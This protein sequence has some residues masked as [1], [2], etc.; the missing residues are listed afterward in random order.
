MF[1]QEVND[2]TLLATAEALEALFLG[3]DHEAADV[4]VIVERAIAQIPHALFLQLDVVEVAD[5]LLNL[6][7]IQNAVDNQFV[8]SWHNNN[9]Q[10]NLRNKRA[11]V[12]ASPACPCDPSD[13]E[14]YIYISQGSGWC[15]A[16]RLNH[17][18]LGDICPSS[19]PYVSHLQRGH[20]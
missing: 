20:Y 8:D 10:F 2:S 15:G 5:D 3:I 7:G 6:R 1:H 12:R 17:L 18:V 16:M 9:L 14:I 11:R 4:P 13:P 19:S